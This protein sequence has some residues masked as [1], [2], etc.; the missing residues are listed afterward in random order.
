M[1]SSSIRHAR[2]S[3]L[4]ASVRDIIDVRPAGAEVPAWC[5]ARGWTEFLAALSDEVVHACERD[6]LARHLPSLPSAPPDLV[7][8]ARELCDVTDLTA[9]QAPLPGDVSHHGASPRKRAQVAAFESLAACVSAGCARVV[10]VGSGHGH[11]TRHLSRALALPA[12]G[13]ERDPAL[14]ATATA[15]TRGE[16]ARFV[17]VDVR[18]MTDPLRATDLVVGLHACGALGDLAVQ[19]AAEAGASVVLLGCCLQKREGDRAPLAPPAG[20]DPAALT[21]PHAVLGLG[22]ARDGDEGVEDDL[23]TRTL[24]RVHRDALRALLRGAGVA[25]A[26]GEEMRGVNRRRAT[27]SL[28]ELVSHAFSLRALTAPPAAAIARALDRA[29]ADYERARRFALPRWM[30]A[31]LIEV[32]VALDRAAHLSGAGYAAE[33]LAAFETSVS[34]RNVAVLGRR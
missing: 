13:W 27:A 18:A 19:R 28:D 34:P 24:A 10:D 17:T 8:L 11:L 3:A 33:A 14:V 20:V 31:R 29:R 15:L 22:N 4:L 12:E 23:A 1:A 2:A 30:L 21:L 5:A 16:D 7:A 32:W 26:A 25:L 9:L 6:G